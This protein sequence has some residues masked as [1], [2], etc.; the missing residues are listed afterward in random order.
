M[1]VKLGEIV[2]FKKGKKPSDLDDRQSSGKRYPYIDIKAFEKQI[3]RQFTSGE[4]TV[5]CEDKDL[6]IVWDGARSG[7]TGKAIKGALGSTLAKIIP[8]E[9]VESDYVYHFLKSQYDTLNQNTKGTGIP[10]LDPL[11]I[12]ELE[13]ELPEKKEQKQIV[14][15]LDALMERV[16]A[17]KARLDKIPQILKRFRQSVLAAAVQNNGEEMIT[18]D[19]CELIQI[20][21]FGTQLHKHDYIS[22]GV[23]LINPTH[24][25][26]GEIIHSS[27]LTVSK[28]KYKTLTNYHLKIGDVIM[29]R[30]GEMARCALIN[31]KENG[32]LCGT[33]S[34]Y[35]RPNLKKVNPN[36]LYWV[37]SNQATKAFLESEAI[38]TTMS[39][40]NLSIANNIPIII[41]TLKEQEE[42][43]RRVN[44]LFAFA[45]KVEARYVKAKAQLDKLP[46]SILAKAFGGELVGSIAKIKEPV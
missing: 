12:N 22:N 23:P 13:L 24:I 3:Y 31:S 7:L 33:G 25:Q 16:N 5:I 6:V 37:L 45:D 4:K 46:Q 27:S 17:N 43:V 19:I 40:L 14:A 26:Q 35:F 38:G 42:I 32:W 30:R 1:I 28:D 44:E 34:L 10:H 20:G 36:Y 39:N 41:P 8:S 18:R 15:K 2:K 11:I 29:G 9:K 21:P